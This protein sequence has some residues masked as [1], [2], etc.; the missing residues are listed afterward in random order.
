MNTVSDDRLVVEGLK[1]QEQ[2][3]FRILY[4]FYYPVIERFVRRNNGTTDDAQDV[5]QETLIVL[6]E[7]VPTDDFELTSSLK[8]YIF[9]VASN[10]WLK[11]LRTAKKHVQMNFSDFDEE[12]RD[13]DTGSTLTDSLETDRESEQNLISLRIHRAL[14]KITEHCQR[15]IRA[16]FFYDKKPN[17]LGYKNAHTAQNQQYKCMEQLRN[18]TSKSADKSHTL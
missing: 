10:I 18:V 5:F 4:T 13:S 6:L 12:L 11:R 8:T 2:S 7:K 15:L 1:K 9:A 16:V 3:A 14:A 17:E